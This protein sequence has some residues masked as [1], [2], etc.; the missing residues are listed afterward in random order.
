M[1]QNISNSNISNSNISNTNISNHG[2]KQQPIR[3]HQI[4]K[5]FN[6]IVRDKYYS[7]V[8]IEKF[9]FMFNLIYDELVDNRMEHIYVGDKI[10]ADLIQGINMNITQLFCRDGYGLNISDIKSLERLSIFQKICI[11]TELKKRDMGKIL[12]YILNQKLKGNPSLHLMFIC[13][14]ILYHYDLIKE[15]ISK[16][17]CIVYNS[18]IVQ[19]CGATYNGVIIDMIAYFAVKSNDFIDIINSNNN[20]PDQC[21]YGETHIKVRNYIRSKIYSVIKIVASESQIKEINDF[22]CDQNIAKIINYWFINDSIIGKRIHGEQNYILDY[23]LPYATYNDKNKRREEHMKKARSKRATDFD[24]NYF[25]IYSFKNAIP[26]LHHWGVIHYSIIPYLENNGIIINENMMM[27]MAH[28]FD[29]DTLYWFL[30]YGGNLTNK[31]LESACYLNI[32]YVPVSK[33]YEILELYNKCGILPSKTAFRNIIKSVFNYGA[34]ILDSYANII[35][36]DNYTTTTAATYT[37]HNDLNDNTIKIPHGINKIRFYYNLINDAID[38]LVQAGYKITNDDFIFAVKY[39][40]LLRKK[41]IEHITISEGYKKMKNYVGYCANIAIIYY[42][43]LF[44]NKQSNKPLAVNNIV[45]NKTYTYDITNNN[46]TQKITSN[47]NI[48]PYIRDDVKKI[49]GITNESI[50]YI[51]FRRTLLLYLKNNGLLTDQGIKLQKPFIT[52]KSE[53][54]HTIDINNWVYSLLNFNNDK[55]NI[56]DS[57]K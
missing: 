25:P 51:D 18:N 29:R 34:Y 5:E 14:L 45:R 23:S 28:F 47:E 21:L 17:G 20:Y 10:V 52:G 1:N 6:R 13:Y 4:F 38:I 44:A 50:T 32:G 57:Q 36:Y 56:I 54:L 19:E 55:T 42:D 41:Y 39:T 16:N 22:F 24:D 53:L 26:V 40:V 7:H 30:R 43:Q 46:N 8:A 31:I 2:R 3:R 11:H 37:D 27:I 15:Y 49:I 48:N 12:S 33:K 9:N 35:K